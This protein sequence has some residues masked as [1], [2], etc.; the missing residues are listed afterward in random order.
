M[1]INGKLPQCVCHKCVCV[2]ATSIYLYMCV[3]V[4]ADKFLFAF[5]GSFLC[6]R[7][8]QLLTASSQLAASGQLAV[9]VYVHAYVCVCACVSL[10]PLSSI[11]VLILFNLRN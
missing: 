3:C 11:N 5:F 1:K 8:Q 4:R 2:C 9:C 7:R 10:S 6:S